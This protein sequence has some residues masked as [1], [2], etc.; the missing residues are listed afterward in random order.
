MVDTVGTCHDQ[1]LDPFWWNIVDENCDYAYG[2]DMGWEFHAHQGE[3]NLM[4]GGV[5][6]A[7]TGR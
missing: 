1:S 4:P 5:R 6:D 3:E 7:D 2:C